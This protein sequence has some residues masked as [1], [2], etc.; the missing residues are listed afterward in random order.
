MIWQRVSR[1]I[2][3]WLLE[4]TCSS[5]IC[6][7]QRQIGYYVWSGC[8]RSRGRTHLEHTFKWFDL[9]GSGVRSNRNP[10]RN[11]TLSKLT[12]LSPWA[13]VN[14]IILYFVSFDLLS[15]IEMFIVNNATINSEL[16]SVITEGRLG[17]RCSNSDDEQ[18]KRK[19]KP[20]IWQKYFSRGLLLQGTNIYSVLEKPDYVRRRFFKH[21]LTPIHR[22]TW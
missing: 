9:H 3:T 19:E 17:N 22:F 6:F 7:D 5:R 4:P 2:S 11:T 21:M 12:I 1:R 13:T 18:A 15:K 8:F 10:K 20:Q 16:N 14:F